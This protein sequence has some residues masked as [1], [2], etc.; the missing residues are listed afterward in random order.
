MVIVKMID[1]ENVDIC[2]LKQ[3]VGNELVIEQDKDLGMMEEV[4]FTSPVSIKLHLIN[5]GQAI[6]ITGHLKGQMRLQCNRCLEPFNFKLEREFAIELEEEKHKIESK[7]IEYGEKQ[8]KINDLDKGFYHSEKIDLVDEI[9]QQI[10]LS[11]PMK[12]VCKEDCL[13]LC[14]QCGVNLNKTTCNCF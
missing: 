12:A 9:R 10:I 13:G 11:L 2:N 6:K 8:L 3:Q 14:S 5:T 7:E 4:E 1:L